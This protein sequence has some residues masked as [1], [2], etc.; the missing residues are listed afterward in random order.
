MIKNDNMTVK[1][2][3]WIRRHSEPSDCEHC[4]NLD[5]WKLMRIA[6]VAAITQDIY[7]RSIATR[8]VHSPRLAFLECN[9]CKQVRLVEES[10]L[11]Q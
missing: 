8:D 11:E 2:E 10:E 5:W 9:N 7:N 1:V 4:E 3:A 6:G